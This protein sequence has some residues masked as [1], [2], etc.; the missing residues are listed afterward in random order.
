[1]PK[2]YCC[3]RLKS[4]LQ[5]LYGSERPV[6]EN[7]A[8]VHLG[9]VTIPY[10]NALHEIVSLQQLVDIVAALR[11][12][13][14]V[15]ID[16]CYKHHPSM[17]RLLSSKHWICSTD[18]PPCRCDFI[19][20]EFKTNGHLLTADF[21][22]ASRWTSVQY[23][24][25][26]LRHGGLTHV[27]TRLCNVREVL[28][29]YPN[30]VPMLATHWNISGAVLTS[31]FDFLL[32]FL[33]GDVTA[34]AQDNNLFRTGVAELKSFCHISSSDKAK[35]HPIFCC[36]QASKQRLATIMYDP[37]QFRVV[38][39]APAA[40]ARSIN[41]IVPNLVCKSDTKWVVP[42]LL[43]KPHKAEFRLLCQYHDCF[44][45]PLANLVLHMSSLI[46][47][48]FRQVL[49]V[50]ASTFNEKFGANIRL[51]N[52]VSDSLQ[53]A[54]NIPKRVSHC[55]CFT[56]DIAKCYDVLTLDPADPDSIV[57]RMHY[58]VRMI[59][60]KVLNGSE[61]HFWIKRKSCVLS[62]LQYGVVPDDQ[63]DVVL[64]AENQPFHQ[65]LTME[66]WVDLLEILLLHAYVA[67]NGQFFMRMHGISQGTQPAV[68]VVNLH[69]M[70]YELEFVLLNM[71]SATGRQ[72]IIDIFSGFLRLLDDI[73]NWGGRR[74]MMI[75]PKI[76]PAY[77]T[78]IKTWHDAT[79]GE[80]YDNTPV[81]G[82]GDY[83]NMMCILLAD[84][85]VIK[86][87]TFKEDKLPFSPVQYILANANR[88]HTSA[89]K[90]ILGQ[91]IV[92]VLLNDCKT[93]CIKHF[94]K[95]THIFM[96][97]GFSRSEINSTVHSYI[98][99]SDFSL[100]QPDYEPLSAWNIACTIFKH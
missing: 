63:F 74:C 53:A 6:T 51:D 25:D 2:A 89:L 50:T 57:S 72:D 3:A 84:G 55:E 91:V 61:M 81:V 26:L 28:T 11:G 65:K 95:L 37:L 66:N 36:K 100:L 71:L 78:I 23:V 62:Q 38:S 76:Y 22:W 83:L 80:S 18:L 60:H 45:T 43:F 90:V 88:S 64:S 21:G 42:T 13:T 97:N 33:C 46:D 40:I 31:D 9:Y 93:D 17:Q 85:R 54:I 70:T 8:R 48:C 82:Y 67:F 49:R 14:P 87:S 30:A 86:R 35:S 20:D 41:A 69:F 44:L 52:V 10:Q 24:L 4:G 59:K 47:Q 58:A 94:R 73:S 32:N 56:A 79:N 7:T 77:A 1:M 15:S 96:R 75:L 98:T 19:D 99:A 92:A 29:S 68:F 39:P 34:P 16:V 12:L 27:P 5:N